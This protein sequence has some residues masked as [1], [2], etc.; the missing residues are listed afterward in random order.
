[1]L[2]KLILARLMC[3]LLLRV[4]EYLNRPKW[5]VG[6]VL[7][8]DKEMLD[9]NRAHRNQKKPTDV[10][11]FPIHKF[12]RV[13]VEPFRS[14][15]PSQDKQRYALRGVG[16]VCCIYMLLYMLLYVYIV[17]FRSFIPSKDK[18]RYA[19]RGMRC[20]EWV[21]YA[22]FTCY[23]IC[24]YMYILYISGLSYLQKTNRGM[25]CVVCAAWSGWRM[26]YLYDSQVYLL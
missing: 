1:M 23:Y 3:A 18:Q 4:L 21:A 13:G 19:L 16:G 10:L 25:R 2:V 22:V 5:K 6:L 9:M 15:V 14:F 7:V 24:Y 8:G 11:S 17:Y 12:D 26:L 20:V